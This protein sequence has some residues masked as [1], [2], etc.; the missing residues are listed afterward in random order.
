VANQGKVETFFWSLL[1]K[2]EDEAVGLLD[3]DFKI[4]EKSETDYT[5][6]DHARIAEL[7]RRVRRLLKAAMSLQTDVE[8]CFR[9]NRKPEEDPLQI[10]ADA[11]ETFAWHLLKKAPTLAMY[12]VIGPPGAPRLNPPPFAGQASLGWRI[13]MLA[14]RMAFGDGTPDEGIQSDTAANTDPG[15][16]LKR[17][18]RDIV[19]AVLTL[20]AVIGER[21]VE[22]ELGR[23]GWLP[24]P[25][26]AAAKEK[27]KETEK[28]V[29]PKPISDRADRTNST[30]G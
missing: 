27:E 17:Y 21:G 14:P 10:Q 20:A 8:A 22:W 12:I 26:P 19:V 18:R 1:D 24:Q 3:E 6:I 28:K 11:E 30:E 5:P 23:W 7:G 2:F 13:V 16:T 29:A 9:A 25:P 4:Q 15:A